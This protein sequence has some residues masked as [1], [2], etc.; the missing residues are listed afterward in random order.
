M[1]NGFLKKNVLNLERKSEGVIDGESG[2]D[3]TGEPT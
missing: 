3:E 1:G 2:E